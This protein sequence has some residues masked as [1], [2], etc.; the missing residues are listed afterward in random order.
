MEAY[1]KRLAE[2]DAAAAS[3]TRLP[4]P[5][6]P[7]EAAPPD[8]AAA[9]SRTELEALKDEF[10]QEAGRV[11]GGGG[12]GGS[13]GGGGGG[14]P[15]KIRGDGD[16]GAK[17]G[18]RPRVRVGRGALA[19]A[20]RSRDG[21]GR[22]RLLAGGLL[23]QRRSEGEEGEPAPFASGELGALLE[24]QFLYSSLNEH[25]IPLSLTRALR[26]RQW[27]H[28]GRISLSWLLN[29]FAFVFLLLVFLV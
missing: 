15:A 11:G 25:L 18:G 28:V 1:R 4:A 19:A 10:E 26:L 6:A 13:G 23:D 14:G 16:G 8:A 21:N 27:R 24:R 22:R 29:V 2:I 12:G 20:R 5:R 9:R 17:V 3:P 7:G